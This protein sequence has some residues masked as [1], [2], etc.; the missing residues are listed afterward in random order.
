MPADFNQEAEVKCF[1]TLNSLW[2]SIRLI[3]FCSCVFRFFNSLVLSYQLLAMP[4]RVPIM[5]RSS[6]SFLYFKV[7]CPRQE[8]IKINIQKKDELTPVS[9][10]GCQESSRMDFIHPWDFSELSEVIIRKYWKKESLPNVGPVR[11][12]RPGRHQYRRYA[13]T[14]MRNKKGNNLNFAAVF[15]GFMWIPE[16][17]NSNELC[18]LC[19]CLA[20][21][22]SQ[23]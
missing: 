5:Y 23:S 12:R 20:L 19:F 18:D 4:I 6:I 15:S 11:Q 3:W 14:V 21:L 1:Q 16:S 7:F 10:E 22:R 8:Y 13:T 2:S 17:V 9:T